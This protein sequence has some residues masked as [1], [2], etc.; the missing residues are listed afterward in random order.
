MHKNK[1]GEKRTI[2][3]AWNNINPTEVENILKLFKDSEYFDLKYWDPMDSKNQT[4][5]N[6]YLGDVSAPVKTWMVGN[7]LYNQLSFNVIER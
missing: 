1:I 3:L 6:F 7:K 4:V 5:K 2:S